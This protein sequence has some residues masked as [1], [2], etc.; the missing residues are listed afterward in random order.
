MPCSAMQAGRMPMQL[1]TRTKYVWLT[2]PTHITTN[3]ACSAGTAWMYTVALSDCIVDAGEET[4]APDF[5]PGDA[6]L[7]TK[8][9]GG[10]VE[11]CISGMDLSCW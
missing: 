9:D 8:A 5:N 11:A 2:Q 7:Y 3:V 6:V 1:S 10:Q 4:L